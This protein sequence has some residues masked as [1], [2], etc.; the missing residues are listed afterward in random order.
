MMYGY[1]WEV[2]SLPGGKIVREGV[3]WVKLSYTPSLVSSYT[4]SLVS[5]E[6]HVIIW[7]A[8]SREA[9]PKAQ[10]SGSVSPSGLSDGLGI[11]GS[12]CTCQ[13]SG[14]GLPCPLLFLLPSTSSFFRSKHEALCC[15][16]SVQ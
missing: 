10:K 4:L 3:L 16:C 15:K 9:E 6:H 14:C 8:S 12:P 5:V 7:P 2:L 1:I 11:T 13:R